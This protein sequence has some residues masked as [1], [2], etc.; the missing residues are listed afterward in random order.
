MNWRQNPQRVAWL[1]L[2][3][4]FLLCCLLAVV[5][6]L[7]GRSYLLH[8]AEAKTAY[9]TAMAGTVQ[10]RAPNA[11]DPVAVTDRRAA[12]EGSQVTTDNTAKALLTVFADE[13]AGQVLGTV[14]LFQD[15]VV[16]IERARTPRFSLSSDP[17]QLTFTLQRGR[18]RTTTQTADGRPVR[19]DFVTPQ[20]S[21]TLGPGTFDIAIEKGETVV[22]VRLGTAQVIAANTL[23]TVHSG[24]RVSVRAD[25]PPDLPVTD[26][27]NLVLNGSFDG[28]LAPTWQSVS[29]IETGK[30]LQPG[31]VTQE[32]NDGRQMLRFT[33]TEEDGAPSEIGVQQAVN[34]DVQGYDSLVLRLDV[35]LL[36]QSVPGG[37]YRASEYPVMVRIN[38]SD[39]YGKDLPWVQGFYYMDL[40]T[41]STW[42]Q[43][44]GE[45]IPLGIWYTYE[46]PNLFDLLR[47]TRPARI[48]TITIYAAGHDY[49]SRVTD[50]ALTV[51]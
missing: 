12:A 40:P 3:A 13:A 48:N 36:Y 42:D 33:R 46:S 31:V 19:A 45:K 27:L 20:A 43:P 21:V 28:R 49:D 30:G 41:K 44:T 14:Q 37:G 38:Y 4:S 11:D 50:V 34:R 2:L 51:R 5:V 18:V 1:I 7:G 26:A 6:P 16:R 17:N 24:E 9:V 32:Q 8:A 25:A 23:V 35:Q 22:R 10:L 47:D 15:T 29:N 39:I